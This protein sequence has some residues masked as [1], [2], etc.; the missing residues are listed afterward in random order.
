MTVAYRA[1]VKTCI[2]SNW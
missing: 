2:A 1:L